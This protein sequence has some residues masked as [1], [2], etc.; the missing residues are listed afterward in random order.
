MGGYNLT[1]LHYSGT[2]IAFG[3]D[4]LLTVVGD[5][6]VWSLSFDSEVSRY[7]Y[8]WSSTSRKGE[9]G[10]REER[11]GLDLFVIVKAGRT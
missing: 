11:R 3:S 10:G 1:L 2:I 7:I 8:V 5:V 4:S 6:I 9:G